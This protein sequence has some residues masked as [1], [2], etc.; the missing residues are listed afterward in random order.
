[1]MTGTIH[2]E[3]ILER[4]KSKNKWN[5]TGDYLSNFEKHLIPINPQMQQTFKQCVVIVYHWFKKMSLVL[6]QN[7]DIMIAIFYTLPRCAKCGMFDN[8]WINLCDGYIGCGRQQFDGSGGNACALRHY[9]LYHDQTEIQNQGNSERKRYFSMVVKLGTI[10]TYGAD[11][12]DYK[13]DVMVMDAVFIDADEDDQMTIN[14]QKN[15]NKRKEWSTESALCIEEL[16]PLLAYW[17]IK[18]GSMYKFDK[19]MEEW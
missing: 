5:F 11:V 17:G 8:L 13:R 12:F 15:R 7:I 1:M 6:P 4:L 10:S 18:M 16:E 19:T 9:S 3:P 2:I 14:M